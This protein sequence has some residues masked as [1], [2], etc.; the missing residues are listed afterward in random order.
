MS[1]SSSPN[2]PTFF[3]KVGVGKEAEVPQRRP[4]RGTGTARAPPQS[5]SPIGSVLGGESFS[6]QAWGL[7]GAVFGHSLPHAVLKEVVLVSLVLGAEGRQGTRTLSCPIEWLRRL[8]ECRLGWKAITVALGAHQWRFS[9]FG[10]LWL[11]RASEHVWWPLNHFVRDRD[12]A[13]KRLF[14]PTTMDG[15]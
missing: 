3:K 2:A 12:L 6:L 14:L 13:N 15:A 4:P 5:T 7:G 9:L 8:L 11:L 10:S 1:G